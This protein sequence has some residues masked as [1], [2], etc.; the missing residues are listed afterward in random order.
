MAVIICNTLV[1]NLGMEIH[2]PLM[3]RVELIIVELASATQFYASLC[4]ILV[5]NMFRVN[6]ICAYLHNPF[7]LYQFRYDHSEP[8]FNIGDWSAIVTSKI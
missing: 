5:G 8:L 2:R 1:Q 4:K 3:R 7:S 6:K